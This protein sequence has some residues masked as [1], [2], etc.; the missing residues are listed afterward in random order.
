MESVLLSIPEAAKILKVSERLTWQLVKA[1]KLPSVRIGLR[2]GRVLIPR[3]ALLRWIA[4]KTC[5]G[6]QN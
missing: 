5:G 4:N 6:E 2:R 3:E 1:G